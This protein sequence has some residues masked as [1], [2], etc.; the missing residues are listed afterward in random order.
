MSVDLS[1]IDKEN[2]KYAI[3]LATCDGVI[4][5]NGDIFEVAKV[6]RHTAFESVDFWRNISLATE[7][8][9][10]ACLLKHHV[11]FFHRRA[12]GH[13]GPKATAFTNAWLAQILKEKDISYIAQINTGTISTTLKHAEAEFFTKPWM[14]QEKVKLIREMFYVI[15]RTRRNRNTHF[16][17]PNQSHIDIAEVEM[18]YLPLLNMLEEIYNFSSTPSLE[19]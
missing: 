6:E 2:H 11:N 15:I 5:Y 4:V 1:D 9:L 16:F 12:H 14:D 13:Y 19:R 18:I 3:H 17:F 7:I 10:K 8:L